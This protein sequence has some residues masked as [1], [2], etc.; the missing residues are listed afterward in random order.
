MILDKL[1]GIKGD[2]V[3]TDDGWKS[4]DL[5]KLCQTLRLYTRRSPVDVNPSE[6]S[7][8]LPRR[9]GKPS[10]SRTQE[11]KQTIKQNTCVYCD[12]TLHVTWECPKITTFDERKRFLAQHSLCFSC[13][14]SHAASRYGSKDSCQRCGRQHHN[15]TTRSCIDS[16]K[17]GRWD[18]SCRECE[19]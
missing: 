13:T 6:K 16:R 15:T 4:W 3:R 14:R 10:N 12:N 5:V 18:I 11:P 8:P 2:L 17:K 19:G 7:D 9:R 1:P